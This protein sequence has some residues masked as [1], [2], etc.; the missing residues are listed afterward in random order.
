MVCWS[1]A[2]VSKVPRIEE[3]RS[4]SI[5]G[6]GKYDKKQNWERG[7]PIV[8]KFKRDRDGGL[9][10]TSRSVREQSKKYIH[11]EQTSV[12]KKMR[13]TSIKKSAV[14][15]VSSVGAFQKA[16]RRQ[17]LARSCG[18]RGRAIREAMSRKQRWRKELDNGVDPKRITLRIL[19]SRQLKLQQRS[20]GLQQHRADIDA[21]MICA[22]TSYE[23]SL[24]LR[25]KIGRR[26][27]FESTRGGGT[28]PLQVQEEGKVG[29]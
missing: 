20:L 12:C 28:S 25:Q 22:S 15:S 8:N 13:A 1:S 29:T 7:I 24:Q 16:P 10:F 14:V 11:T 19:I 3:P 9:S 27:V 4:L 2:L 5:Q 6:A 18:R 21:L 26:G 23:K 17:T